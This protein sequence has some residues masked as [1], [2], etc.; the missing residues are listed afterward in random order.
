MHELDVALGAEVLAA[1][2][3]FA[4][5]SEVNR[6]RLRTVSVRILVPQSFGR[7]RSSTACQKKP[8]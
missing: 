5:T 3:R 6:R 7:A 8:F 4:V 1:V 2:R